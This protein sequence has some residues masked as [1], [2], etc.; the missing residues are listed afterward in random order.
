MESKISTV[1]YAPVLHTSPTVADTTITISGSVPSGTRVN[2]FHVEWQRDTSVGCS[3]S[4]MRRFPVNQGFTGSYTILELEPG[5]RYTITVTVSN[6]AGSSPVSNSVTA[7]TTETGESEISVNIPVITVSLYTQ[8]PLVVPPQS[9]V[10]QSLPVV[11]PYTG[12]RY[13]VSIVMDR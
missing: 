7:T 12:E 13:H 10:V 3:K 4:N 2:D 9:D 1:P 5:N 11:L 8:L 6:G